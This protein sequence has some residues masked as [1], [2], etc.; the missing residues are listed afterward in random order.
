MALI[1]QIIGAESGGN[2][3]AQNPDS[4]AGGVGQF[5]N[6]TWLSTVRAHRPDLADRSDA[7]ILALKNDPQLGREMTAAYAA[8]NQ[9]TL[10]KNGLPVTPGT[11]YLAHFAGPQ[12]AISVL[13][14][15]PSAPVGQVLGAGVVKANPFLAGMTVGDLRAW[16][17]R[18]MGGAQSAPASPA[19]PPNAALAP[20]PAQAPILPQQVVAA[21]QTAPQASPNY[22]AQMPAQQMQAPPIYYA[23]RRQIDLSAL[24]AAL[25]QR[26]FFSSQG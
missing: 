21:P 20:P 11:T 1:D 15:D 23:P 13:K 10:Q 5:I 6:S 12:G 16:A 17:D 22:F 18:K 25:A 24:Q 19:R 3:N 2:P 4:S 26:P 9:A 7:D 8:D 14:A